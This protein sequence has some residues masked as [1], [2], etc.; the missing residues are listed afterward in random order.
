MCVKRNDVVNAHVVELLKS[1]WAIQ[2]L[3]CG[4]SVLTAFIQK[5]KN[6]SNSSCFAADSCDDTLQICKVIIRRHMI[7]LSA[8]GVGQAV[9]CY[10]NH[11]EQVVTSYRLIDHT[12]GFSGTESRNIRFNNIAFSGIV[13]KSNIVL[14]LVLTV[15]SPGSKI[16]IDL[17]TELCAAGRRDQPECTAWDSFQDSFIVWH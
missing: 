9:V 4:S 15:L 13:L 2:R 12:F 11:N 6:H 14:M 5:W 10:I 16:I 1:Q 8:K 3:S 17:A 7:G